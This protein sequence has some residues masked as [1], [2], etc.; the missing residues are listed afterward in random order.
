[1]TNCNYVMAITQENRIDTAVKV[2]DILTKFGCQIRA[3]LGL[4]EG[5]PNECSSRGMVIL[6]LCGDDK[7]ITELAEALNQVET[8]KAKF[9]V[10]E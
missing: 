8:V 9:M 3:R 1:M 2:Q 4:H 6:Q 5:T 7:T 10:I